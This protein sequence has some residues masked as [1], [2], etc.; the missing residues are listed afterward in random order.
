MDYNEPLRSDLI[1]LNFRLE[2]GPA[3]KKKQSSETRQEDQTPPLVY[4]V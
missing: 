3:M 1:R 2:I 4:D